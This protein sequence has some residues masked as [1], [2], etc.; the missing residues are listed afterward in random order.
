MVCGSRCASSR[1]PIGLLHERDAD[2]YCERDLRDGDEVGRGD[3]SRGA[4]TE[5]QRRPWVSGRVQVSARRAVRS[6]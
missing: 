4:V 3:S 6:V 1:D 2:S 5:D